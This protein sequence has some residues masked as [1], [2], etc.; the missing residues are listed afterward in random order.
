MPK[1]ISYERRSVNHKKHAFTMMPTIVLLLILIMPA[2]VSCQRAQTDPVRGIAELRALITSSDGRPAATDLQR[3]ESKYPQTRT[4]ALAKFLR[5][6]LYYSAQNFSAAIDALDARAIDTNSSIGDYAYFLRA[7]SEAAN[8]QKGEALRDYGIVYTKHA[9]SLRARDA[10]LQAAR[11]ALALGDPA[12][13]MKEIAAMVE[14]KDPDAVFITAQVN[15]ATGKTDEAIRIYRKIYFEM[16]ATRAAVDAEAKLTTLG[17]SINDNPGTAEELRARS[18]ALFQAKQ[19][20]EAVKSFDQL[21]AR[22]PDAEQEDEINLHRGISQLNARMPAQA[23]TSLAR[24]SER[25][26]NLKAEAL[27]N[28]AEALRRSNRAGESALIVDKL[29]KQYSATRWAQDALYNLAKD[30]DKQDR[31]SEA[32]ARFRQLFTVYPKSQYAPEAS[33]YVG[34]HAYL[35]KNYAEAARALEQHLANYRYPETKYIG[36][37]GFW[38]AKSE[39]RMGNRARALALYDIVIERYRYG[40]HGYIANI[41]AAALRSADP[42]LKAEQAKAGS[43]L[44]RI[45]RNALHVEKIHET[46]NGSEA[47]YVARADDLELIGLDELAVKELNKAIESAPAS[48]QLNLRLAQLYS[49]RGDNF[50]ATLVLRRGYPDIYSYKESDVPREAWE[51]MFPLNNWN[52]IKEEAKR[53]GIDPYI[54]AGLIRQESVFNPTA[55][56]RVGARGLM[57]VMPA[58]A[59]VI[60]KRQGGGAITA[61]DLYNP[62]VNIKLGMNYLAQMLG[63]FNNRIEYAAAAYNAGPGRARA[64]IAAR[65]NFDI[66]DWIESIPFS[67]TRGYVMGVLR[68][69]ANYRRLYKE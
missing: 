5:G 17:A 69:A 54:V 48:P 40:Y 60:S 8:D 6:Y 26:A 34:R 29:L 65:G 57:Q 52:T 32:A 23:I 64:W 14:A 7:E 46:A 16:P 41:R 66:E 20:A 4:A 19:Y 30:L 38:A 12:S 55:I 43:D 39:E 21:V 18:E 51:I 44:E 22:F 11:M 50:Q 59:Q 36:E 62:A 35:A 42:A 63:Q 15:E 2:T 53:Y 67:E 49:R 58:T 47:N 27:M 28:Q 3:I 33:Y 25:D 1:P 37:A 13:A 45:R 68:Y 24:V 10:K 56:S 61:A 9:D 31:E